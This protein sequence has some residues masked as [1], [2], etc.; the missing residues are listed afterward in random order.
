MEDV[1]AWLI[2]NG[3]CPV[4]HQQNFRLI[5]EKVHCFL[6]CENCEFSKFFKIISYEED[7]NELV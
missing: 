4:C 7:K 6:V 1:Y 5:T 3:E 2:K